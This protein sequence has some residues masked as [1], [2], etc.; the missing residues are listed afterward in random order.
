[1]RDDATEDQD[2]VSDRTRSAAVPLAVLLGAFGAHRFYVGKT[3]SAILMACTL[4]GMG[5]WWMADVILLL[6][7]EFRDADGRRVVKW[8]ADSPG[9][10]ARLATPQIES[11]RDEM[12]QM[13]AE[14]TELAERVDFMERML[15]KARER[16]AIPPGSR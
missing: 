11:V 12:D 6:T 4:G 2:N 10:A 9:R 14:M 16:D 8:S 1:M 7:G 15:A 13:R 5:L 3:G